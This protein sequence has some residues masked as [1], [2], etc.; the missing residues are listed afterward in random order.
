MWNLENGQRYGF[1]RRRRDTD[2]RTNI[3]I[4]K[5]KERGGR[6]WEAGTDTHTQLTLCLK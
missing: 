6:N 4:P 5:G 2:E 1:Q 3:W